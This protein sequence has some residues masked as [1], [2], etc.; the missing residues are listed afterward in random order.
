MP[1]ARSRRCYGAVA[2]RYASLPRPAPLRR[3]TD[4]YWGRC[5]W[6]Q[7]A[8]CKRRGGALVRLCPHGA[9]RTAR[10]R[11][12]PPSPDPYNQEPPSWYYELGNNVPEADDA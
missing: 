5:S 4:F 9:G 7:C 2:P 3:R 12:R 1:P 10:S 8:I 11:A 6:M